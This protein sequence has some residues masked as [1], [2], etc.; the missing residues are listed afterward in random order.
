MKLYDAAQA[1][2]KSRFMILPAVMAVFLYGV[3]LP[4]AILLSA[5]PDVWFTAGGYGDLGERE[6]VASQVSLRVSRSAA[7]SRRYGA[8]RERTVIYRAIDGS[9]LE[10][11]M[12]Y[13]AQVF[14]ERDVENRVTVLRHVYAVLEKSSY[15]NFF[16]HQFKIQFIPPGTDFQSHLD[17]LH[18]EVLFARWLSLAYSAVSVAV[19]LLRRRARKKRALISSSQD[20][21]LP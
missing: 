8:A 9:G 1:E 14:A 5:V 19:V 18:N 15:P 10:F 21:T 7:K 3:F 12:Q 16:F 20:S 2:P 4:L 6:F 17:T 11:K 13:P